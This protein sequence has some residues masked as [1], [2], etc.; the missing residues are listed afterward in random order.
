MN[1][2]KKFGMVLIVLCMLSGF[3]VRGT[4]M[5]KNLSRVET[6]EGIGEMEMPEEAK[7]ETEGEIGAEAE[8]KSQGKAET[9]A[10]AT[11]EGETNIDVTTEGGTKTEA[12]TEQETKAEVTIEGEAKIEETTEGETK[13]EATTGTETKTEAT[14]GT[15]TKTEA[16]TE[17][18]VKIEATT[19]GEVKEKET[20]EGET[21]AETTTEGGTKAEWKPEIGATTEAE[22]EEA[23]SKAEAETGVPPYYDNRGEHHLGVDTP[24][25]SSEAHP[26]LSDETPMFEAHLEYTPQG[27][28]V[29]G[30][31]KDF[32]DDTILV[33]PMCSTDGESYVECGLEWDLR[34]LNS[35][36]E[37]DLK[38]LQNQKCLFDKHEPLKSYLAK[39]LDHFTIKL[40]IV[41]EEGLTYETQ[42]VVIQREGLQSV[43][44]T[45][46]IY[47]NFGSKLLIREGRPPKFQYY[48]RYQITV[49]EEASSEEI[50]A[51]LPDTL[52]VEIQLFKGLTDYVGE[53][54]VDC[55]VQWK[56]LNLPK[57][58]AGQC[59]TISDAAEELVVPA[60]TL[61]TT[62][63]GIYQLDHSIS[64]NQPDISKS[65]EVRI[66]LNVV[67]KD[68]QPDAG[69]Y[70]E[71]DGLHMAFFLKPTGA[72]SIRAYTWTEGQTQWVEHCG[73]S[74]LDAVNQQP[75]TSNSGFVL[76]L[77]NDEEP[78]RSFIKAK[79]TEEEPV[80]FL[81][82]LKI[83]GGVYDGRQIVL[84][85]PSTYQKPIHFPDIGGSGGNQ[86]NAGADNKDDSTVEGQRPGLPQESES[87]PLPKPPDE[88]EIQESK[89]MPDAGDSG[90]NQGNANL[91]IEGG[92]AG[93][94]QRPGLPLGPKD[95]AISN[96]SGEPG[97]QEEEENLRPETG[98]RGIDQSGVS[99]DSKGGNRE[100]AALWTSTRSRDGISARIRE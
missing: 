32:A 78:Y 33:Q 13:T 4:V 94:G 27:W 73:L 36:D 77:R 40:R 28:I 10:G 39:D 75:S 54:I 70:T 84:P 3:F 11:I 56:P 41:T 1:I 66:V 87:E 62:Q 9:K 46:N 71:N 81:V 7:M 21:K 96:P 5:A 45:Y 99:S 95:E 79:E 2:H 34:W 55:P 26:E 44:D 60:G 8:L 88:S 100:R 48:G 50:S 43:P 38:S 49:S 59:I 89:P 53:D 58:T 35:E 86:G 72:T 93:E 18:E 16:T 67:A 64:M 76:L 6:A 51:L 31:F 29:S 25:E 74:L 47:A 12:T 20:T 30:T 57:L 15:E 61:L 22:T 24:G 14:T 52:P 23:E 92:G 19:E 69:L 80:P 91:E 83:E 63:S 90:P 65:G 85:W 82:G 68:K 17:G 37:N 98:D 97:G 42:E